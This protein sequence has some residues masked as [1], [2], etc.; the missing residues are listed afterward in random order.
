[1]QTGQSVIRMKGNA[2][3]Q[4]LSLVSSSENPAF[5]KI[6]ML[7]AMYYSTVDTKTVVFDKSEPI[8]YSFY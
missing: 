3:Q 6:N 2:E 5:A 1:M 8:C 7:T 4:I